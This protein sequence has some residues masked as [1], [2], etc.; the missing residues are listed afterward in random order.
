[1]DTQLR[2]NSHKLMTDRLSKHFA[3][4]GSRTHFYTF[5]AFALDLLIYPFIIIYDSWYN[6][7]FAHSYT[8]ALVQ[9]AYLR[10]S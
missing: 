2:S 10:P 5:L 9:Y 3:L 6:F 7:A 4:S 8:E 1:M